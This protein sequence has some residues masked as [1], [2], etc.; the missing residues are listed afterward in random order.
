MQWSEPLNQAVQE[1][2]RKKV[3]RVH[4]GENTMLFGTGNYQERSDMEVSY[5]DLCPCTCHRVHMGSKHYT[6]IH[7]G[8]CMPMHVYIAHITLLNFQRKE[9]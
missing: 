2:K 9:T 5:G 6:D 8:S 7:S 4:G 3:W 1:A